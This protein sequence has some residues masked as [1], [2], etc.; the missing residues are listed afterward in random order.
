MAE[1]EK[2]KWQGDWLMPQLAVGA[3]M[4]DCLVD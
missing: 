2:R 4:F 1:V 3:L